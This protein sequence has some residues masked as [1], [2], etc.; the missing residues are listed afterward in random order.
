MKLY[1]ILALVLVFWACQ[2]APT[3][4]ESTPEAEPT[5]E[6]V[7]SAA[8]VVQQTIIRHGGESMD[9]FA[10]VF[11][12]RER[13][14]SLLREGGQFQYRREYTNEEGE[15]VQDEL[16]NQDFVRHINGQA[17]QLSAKDS[18]SYA[19]SLNSVIYFA[20]LP[21][22]LHDP[23]VKLSYHGLT[24]ALGGPHYE[25]GV[26][27]SEDGGGKDFEDE[28]VYW[29]HQE[30]RTMDYLAYN[31]QVNGGGARFRKAFNAR[32]EQGIRWQ[33]YYNYKPRN[34]SMEVLLFDSLYAAGLMDS[35]STIALEDITVTT[36]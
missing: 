24:D 18:S 5:T 20:L 23:A 6:A 28:Y 26:T 36:K 32:E 8:W 31:F 7:D 33:D 4:E 35:L 22:L 19:N 29:I 10:A 2:P 13:T 27:F 21:Y 11:T 34:G 1:G 30:D 12:F 25:I 15:T 17:V 3:S 14:Y 9:S 16:T